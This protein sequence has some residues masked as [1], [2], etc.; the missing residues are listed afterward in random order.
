MKTTY[1]IPVRL[2]TAFYCFQVRIYGL[3]HKEENVL[4]EQRDHMHTYERVESPTCSVVNWFLM[5]YLSLDRRG[6]MYP[7]LF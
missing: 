1:V 7:N 3:E 2:P 6:N 5:Y 4:L